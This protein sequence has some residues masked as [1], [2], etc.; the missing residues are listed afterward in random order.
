MPACPSHLILL[1]RL[2]DSNAAPLDDNCQL[3]LIPLV[4][5]CMTRFK[6]SIKHFA[7]GGQKRCYCSRFARFKHTVVTANWLPFK[8]LKKGE[9][10]FKKRSFA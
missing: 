1:V 8:S 9:S 10:F 7:A 3:S 4:I 5:S 6:E 2:W